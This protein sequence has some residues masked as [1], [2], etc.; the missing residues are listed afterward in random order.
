M[1]TQ[2]LLAIIVLFSSLIF[3][4]CIHLDF[5]N[6]CIRGEGPIVEQEL[7]IAEF[8]K[9]DLDASFDVVISQGP[10]QKVLAVGNQNIIEHLNT[11]VFGGQWNAGFE[12]GCYSNFDLTV[13]VT[14]PSI[15]QIKLSGSG[16]VELEDF[17]Q[18]NDLTVTLTGS[19]DFAM[20]EFE[21]AENLY[22]N[23]HSSGCFYAN[24]EITCFKTVT[25]RC[26]G[27]GDFKGFLIKAKEYSAKTSGSGNCY[28]Y[29]ED[30]LTATTSGSGD[31]HYK[32]NPSVDSHSSGSGRVVHSN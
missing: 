32:G 10:V 12:Q 18:E 31:I 20:N 27:S 17:N 1:K 15:D 8:S 4:S 13:Y 19:G 14:I 29:A 3:S 16:D 28:V 2:N 6:I 9:I 22:A 30:Y 26:T 24:K 25:V 7:S 5:D 23:L 21:S 11:N